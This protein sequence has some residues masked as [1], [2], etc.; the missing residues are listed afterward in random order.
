M[1]K[2]QAGL[3]RLLWGSAIAFSLALLLAAGWL[4]STYRARIALLFAGIAA[5]EKGDYTSVPLAGAD[6]DGTIVVSSPGSV[7]MRRL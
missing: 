2:A 3:A 7:V 6:S 1:T 5:A 4:G